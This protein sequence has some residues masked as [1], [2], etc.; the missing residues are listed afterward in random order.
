MTTAQTIITAA[1][2]ELGV[3]ESGQTPSNEDLAVCL[4]ALNVLADAWLVEPGYAYSTTLVSA[5]LPAATQSRTIGPAMQF[6]CAR[7]VRIEQPGSYV[8]VG[9][10]DYPLEVVDDVAYNEIALKSVSGAWP[11]VC[12]YDAGSPTGN[13][14]FWPTGACTVYLMVKTPVSQFATLTTSVT[15]TPGMERALKFSLMEEVAGTFS[16]KLT[17]IQHRNAANA[18]RNFKRANFVTPELSVGAAT[19]VPGWIRIKGG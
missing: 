19:N 16:R 4:L 14:Y 10:I 3:T 9:D 7:P 5:A 1:L 17:T 6:A 12:M 2:G 13:V 15:L 11:S 18:R 8:R